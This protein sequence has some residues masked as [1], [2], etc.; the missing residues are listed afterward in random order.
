MARDLCAFAAA[1]PAALAIATPTAVAAAPCALA[2]AGEAVAVE[3]ALDGDTVLLDDGRRVRL[4]GL[5]APKAPLG[6]QAEDWPLD[7]ASRSAL[8]ALATGRVLELREAAA[9]PDRHGRTV[10][11][12]AEIDGPDHAGIG[13]AMLQRGLARVAADP[14]G[15]DCRA[16]LAEAEAGAVGARLGLWSEPYYEVVKASD[17]PALALLSGRFVV[18]EGRVA[19]ARI[20]GGRAYVNFG[21]RWREALSLTFSEAS[22]RKLGGFEALGIEAGVRIRARGVVETR[23]GPTI[24]VT[25]PAQVERLDPAGRTK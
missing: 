7:A 21:R 6:T 9:S 13:V 25:E 24:Y 11:Y 1:A 2:R 15:R 8:D 12:L 19:S 17:G 5:S 22:L 10:G 18:A 16:T 20:S 3:A 23:L 14:A 4:A